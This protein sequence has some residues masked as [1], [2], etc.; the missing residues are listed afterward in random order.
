TQLSGVSPTNAAGGFFSEVTSGGAGGGLTVNT[1][2]LVVEGGAIVSTAVTSRT[3]QGAGGNLTVNAAE[4]VVVRGQ[5]PAGRLLSSLTTAT[6]GLGGAGN[7]TINTG[8]FTLEEGATVTTIVNS[9]G[10][11]NGGNLTI[12][13][14]DRVI[15]QGLS[16]TSGIA[17][18][19][20]AGTFGPGNAGDLTIHTRQLVVQD[21]AQISTSTRQGAGRGGNLTVNASESVILDRS[22]STIRS[23]LFSQAN[24]FATR[25]A[26]TI[27]VNTH[28][29]FMAGGAWISTANQGSGQ[30][31][32][33]F[34]HADHVQLTGTFLL[35]DGTAGQPTLIT[36]DTIATGNAGNLMLSARM[37]EISGGAQ[38][39][40]SALGLGDGG[41]LRVV[42]GTITLRGT[43]VDG[44][45]PSGLFAASGIA[46]VPFEASGSGG[47]LIVVADRIRVENRAQ[48]AVSG[49]QTG[50]AGNLSLTARTISLD[51][52]GSITAATN[53][54]EG[55]NIEL[56]VSQILALRRNSGISATAGGTGNGG[57]I[58]ISNPFVLGVASE[59]TDIIAN[60]F[61]GRGGKI[62]IATPGIFGL[63]NRPRLSPGSDITASSEFGVSGIVQIQFLE[64]DPTRVLT[65]LPVNLVDSAKQIAQSCADQQQSNRFIVTGRGGLSPDP[66]EA[67]NQTGVWLGNAGE[68]GERNLATA[69]ET[70]SETSL[71]PIVEAT[72]WVRDREGGVTLVADGEANPAGLNAPSCTVGTVP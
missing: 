18:T 37:L 60:A 65:E 38:V 53:S 25:D 68:N 31:G 26:G 23:G 24:S 12:K 69:S 59:D 7:L 4:S 13:A 44:T 67:I 66:T 27:T 50:Q 3:A 22:T 41:E 34:I 64:L 5:S 17:T 36:T 20:S 10:I 32:N 56:N 14:T 42:A 58:T 70:A 45:L 46:G 35:P 72:R 6:S 15:I 33:I 16:P 54:G 49:L 21:G 1:G 9:T 43:S 29:L 57:N 30:G 63:Q 52:Q 71:S 19:L 51:S 40:A 2:Q 39:S 28:D 55:G 48:I 8:R 11:G 62:Q 61:E 47:N